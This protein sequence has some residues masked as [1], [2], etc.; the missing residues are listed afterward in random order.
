LYCRVR[1]SEINADEPSDDE[2]SS[3]PDP[4]LE[5]ELQHRLASLY[6]PIPSP[7]TSN[8]I[9]EK[10]A[11]RTILN[12]AQSEL[13]DGPN[14]DDPQEFEFRLFSTPANTNSEQIHAQ[15]IILDNDDSG[16]G[17]G[18]FVIPRRNPDY[19]FTTKAQGE[20]KWRFEHAA[21]NGDDILKA[22][23]QRAWGLEVP[24]RVTVIK[25]PSG[26]KRKNTLDTGSA[27]AEL[28]DGEIKK[29]KLGKKQRIIIRK[30]TRQIAEAEEKR[31]QELALKDE[32]EREKRTRRN[33]EKKLRKRQKE[34]DEKAARRAGG[35]AE[36]QEDIQPDTKAGEK[37]DVGTD[38]EG[39]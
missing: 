4:E 34:K 11:A 15:K 7:I 31:K 35:V 28:I 1:R 32:T 37:S 12:E 20:A 9:Q 36:G 21:V 2:G 33:R 38:D 22:Q 3:S 8:A 39:E 29:R 19:Y 18:G 17:N 16:K 10:K 25:L 6:G 27:T 23:K 24:W 5:R 30:R 26:I 13:S 14:D